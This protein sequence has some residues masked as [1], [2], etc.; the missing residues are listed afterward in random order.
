MSLPSSNDDG[1][2]VESEYESD[3]DAF[4]DVPSV[5]QYRKQG[6]SIYTMFLILSFL[7]LTTSAIIFYTNIRG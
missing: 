6:F 5:P 4:E 2:F 3:L 7:S 1:L